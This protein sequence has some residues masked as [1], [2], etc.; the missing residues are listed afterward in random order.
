MEKDPNIR[1]TCDQALQH[2]WYWSYNSSIMMHSHCKEYC[3]CLIKILIYLFKLIHVKT[4][5]PLVPLCLSGLRGILL[6]IRISMSLSVL[7]SRRILLRAS[8]R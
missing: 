3:C 1:Y 5:Q 6:W 2:P 4:M 8:G 7:R